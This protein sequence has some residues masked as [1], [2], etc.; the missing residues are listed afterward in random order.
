[1]KTKF[2]FC[3]AAA[4][5]MLASGA[6]AQKA[7]R[8]TSVYSSLS[9]GCKT[10]RGG[11]GTDDAF[12]CRGPGRY[13]VRVYF[14]AATMQINAE[15]GDENTSLATLDVGFDQSRTTLEWRLANGKPFAVIMR[16]PVYGDP[17]EGED[18]GKVKGHQLKI[19]GLAGY[20]IDQAIDTATPH[21]NQKAREAA[22]KAYK[23]PK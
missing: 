4:T 17:K 3:V 10:L 15:R 2:T 9:R 11:D 14:S 7:M 5:L 19:T 18:F 22:D 12:L 21:A 13:K 1:M 6:F 20:D 23:A 8:F 16:V